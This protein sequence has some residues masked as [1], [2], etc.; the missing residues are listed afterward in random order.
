MF[1]SVSASIV[2]EDDTSGTVCPQNPIIRLVPSESP[3]ENASTSEYI[4]LESED[5]RV[6]NISTSGQIKLNCTYSR[7]AVWDFQGFQVN[8]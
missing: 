8:S 4:Y 5:G 6:S 7:P 3:E 2:V 1:W